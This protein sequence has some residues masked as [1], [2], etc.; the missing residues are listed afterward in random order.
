MYYYKMGIFNQQ[1]NYNQSTQKENDEL[2][3]LKD[4][5]ARLAP[6]VLRVS[7]DLLALKVLR[8]FLALLVLRVS[9]D[10]LALKVLLVHQALVLISHQMAIMI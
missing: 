4:F 5:L 3:A 7:L 2:L 8:V 10:L 9:L 6:L 1:P